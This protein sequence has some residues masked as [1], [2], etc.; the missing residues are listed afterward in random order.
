MPTTA[1]TPRGDGRAAPL[2]SAGILLL[3]G[4]LLWPAVSGGAHVGWPLAATQLLVLVALLAWTLGMALRGRLEWRRTALD[5][6]LGLLI[7][8]VLLQLAIGNGPL[9]DWALQ[10]PGP[11]PAALPSRFLAL[12]TVSPSQTERSLLLFLTY[13]GVYALVVNL[14]K[15]RRDLDRL[16]RVLLLAGGV[17]AFLSLVDH[18][19]RDA[20]LFWWGHG[21]A[22]PRLAGP[23]VN[24]DHWASWLVMLICL[25]LGYVAARSS[26][27]RGPSSPASLPPLPSARETALRR[28]LPAFGGAI[29]ALAA[30]LTL[31]RGALLAALGAG[32]LLL[33]GLT[34]VRGLRWS[35]VLTAALSAVTL[36]YALWIGIEPLLA[37]FGT[38]DQLSRWAQWR[39][40]LPML[41]SFPVLGVGLGTYKDVYFRFQPAALLPGR[42]YFP[43]A[44]S[45]LL[46][47]AIETGPAGAA[48]FLWA[49]WRVGRDLVGAHLFGRGRCPVTTD[50]RVRRSDPWSVGIML[51]ALGAVAALLAQ[52]AVDFS[53]RIP[54]DG[55]L[56]AAC[57][58]MAT[59]AAHTRFRPSGAGSLA[60]TRTLSL[61]QGM[62]ARAAAG[63]GA[64][65]LAALLASLIVEPATARPASATI[66][67]LTRALA[68]TPSDPYLHERL[69]WALQLEAARAGGQRRAALAHME[70]AVALQTE[71]PLL[72]RSM[73]A[74]ALAG[75]EPRVTLAI[76]AGRAAVERDPSLSPGLVDRL[77]P[78]TLTDAQWTALVPP[79]PVDRVDLARHLESRGLLHEARALYAGALEGTSAPE[80]PVIRWLLA[81]LLLGVHRPAEALAQVDAALAKSPGNPEVLLARAQALEAL[82]APASL[83]AYRA[84]VA[85]AEGRS[86]LVFPTESP[87][88]RAIV[89]ERFGG[90]AR[91]SPARY[92]RA[93]AQR[94]TDERRWEAARDEWERARVDGPLD[95][96]GEF[97]RGLALEA[98]GDRA[99]ALEAFRHAATLDQ[100]LTAFRARLAAGLWENE[101]Y[102]QAI[103]EWQ[104]I[105]SQEPGN[106][107]ARLALARAYLKA[108]DRGR[109][110]GE[111]R[112]VLVLAPGHAEARQAVARLSGI[113]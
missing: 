71:N 56:G 43:Y 111:Y 68:S 48:L 49:V 83:D 59:V 6:P 25:G 105:A 1:A 87:R 21:P 72:Y 27:G 24:P 19:S 2:G 90:D 41:A 9:R 8:L 20:W 18:L 102:M 89:A 84:A 3:S 28:Y 60:G 112:R 51:G 86:G 58:G 61:G 11:E 47:L 13:A 52:S 54:A 50:A 55:V 45:D 39:S 40:S 12:G 91:I 16:V 64:V 14:V 35:L 63:A 42:V 107:E 113:P 92:R 33:R 66:D 101:Q 108:G 23:F 81:R 15:R 70:R 80:E 4:A 85:S 95:A 46:Q 74:L 29:M 110:L 26:G 37:R 17:L 38:S 100:A 77:A 88:L 106:V 57:L 75:P 44:H 82:R 62:P 53:A 99:R 5:L 22:R 76:E 69:A 10:P 32:L 73:A 109:A 34:R 94:L 30:I 36:G 31:S 97:S 78:F 67:E 98:T 79:S 104:T 65:A 93:L 7:L 96:Q 103:A